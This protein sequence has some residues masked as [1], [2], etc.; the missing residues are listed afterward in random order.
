M[1]I[2]KCFAS[3]RL[4]RMLKGEHLGKRNRHTE[5]VFHVADEFDRCL[6]YPPIA[7]FILSTVFTSSD[8]QIF[9]AKMISASGD[10][11]LFYSNL[12][13]HILIHAK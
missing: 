8:S 10:H 9:K 6:L 12:H 4:G 3:S 7:I 11:T 5:K 13:K 2:W 1:S